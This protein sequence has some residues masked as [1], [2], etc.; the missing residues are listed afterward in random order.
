MKSWRFRWF[1]DGEF[2]ETT[3]DAESYP[4]ACYNLGRLMVAMYS[5]PPVDFELDL[6]DPKLSATEVKTKPSE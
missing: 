4:M 5:R 2:H 3:V 1:G 6:R